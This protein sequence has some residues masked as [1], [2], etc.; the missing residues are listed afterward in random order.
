MANNPRRPQSHAGEGELRELHGRRVASVRL[1]TCSSRCKANKPSDYRIPLPATR[2]LIANRGEIASRIQ[3]TAKR[4]GMETVAVYHGEDR[5]APFVKTADQAFELD[6]TPPT[7]AYLDL[8]QILEIARASQSS[9]IHPGY[10]FLA[11]NPQFARATSAQGLTFIGPSAQVIELM[12]DKLRSRDYAQEAGIPV[13]PAVA[14]RGDERAFMHAAES[15][16]YP[17]IVKAAAGG[18]GKG[19]SLVHHPR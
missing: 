2:I 12:G 8:E 7:A 15:L 6:A 5:N 4:L 18:G 11:E 1:T 9:A 13:T 10:G 17:Q 16:G 19:M 3:A 14:Y